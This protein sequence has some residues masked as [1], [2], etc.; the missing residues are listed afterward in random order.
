MRYYYLLPLI[1]ALALRG[2][3]EVAAVGL[4]VTVK[5][6]DGKAWGL[7]VSVEEVSGGVDAVHQVVYGFEIS[8]SPLLVELDV[9]E[10]WDLQAV[11]AVKLPVDEG[12]EA[13]LSQAAFAVGF[14]ASEGFEAVE[15]LLLGADFAVGLS[16]IVKLEGAGALCLEAELAVRLFGD[17]EPDDVEASHLECVAETSWHAEV[18]DAETLYSADAVVL[19]VGVQVEVVQILYVRG[20][21]ERL[22][23]AVRLLEGAEIE[24]AVALQWEA[25]VVE[26]LEVLEATQVFG[27]ALGSSDCSPD[28]D[29]TFSLED[30]YSLPGQKRESL[31]EMEM[32]TDAAAD[33]QRVRDY[34]RAATSEELENDA[35]AQLLQADI[36]HLQ[37][38][39]WVCDQW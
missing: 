9:V 6:V 2:G 33:C 1:A 31:L 12:V 39:D 25:F 17:W 3:A 15:R 4:L 27:L 19:L 24:S 23:D 30:S 7:E 20:A 28:L 21:V 13:A 14:P 26:P 37:E 29:S 22:E 16:V 34:D 18:D 38:A 11:L 36:D 8:A 32:E 35:E 10:A 5:L